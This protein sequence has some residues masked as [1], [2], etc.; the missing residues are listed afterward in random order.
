MRRSLHLP[1]FPNP[2]RAKACDEPEEMPGIR[3]LDCVNY[4][5]CLYTAACKDWSGFTCQSCKCYRA[6]RSGWVKDGG[7]FLNMMRGIAE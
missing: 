7:Q 5:D 6:D 2:I 1:M 3:R 4:E